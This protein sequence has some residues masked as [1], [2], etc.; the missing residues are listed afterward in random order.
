[1]AFCDGTV[2]RMNWTVDATIHQELG[3][4]MDGQPTQL[5]AIDGK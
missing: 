3:N 1:M 5:Q 4:R 2:R